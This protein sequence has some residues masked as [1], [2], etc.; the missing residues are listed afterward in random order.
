MKFVHQV[1]EIPS[2]TFYKEKKLPLPTEA[3]KRMKRFI[4]EAS[5]LI[6]YVSRLCTA[7]DYL[8][9]GLFSEPERKSVEAD[10]SL[11]ITSIDWELDKIAISLYEKKYPPVLEDAKTRLLQKIEKSIKEKDYRNAWLSCMDLLRTVHD[12]ATTEFDSTGL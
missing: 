9:Q 10:V 12:F 5:T 6:S 11:E 2:A 8:S 3:R 7:I 4:S 1:E